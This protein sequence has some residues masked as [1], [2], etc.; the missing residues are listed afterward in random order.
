MLAARQSDKAEE[1]AR[2]VVELDPNNADGYVLLGNALTCPEARSRTPS[3][4]LP[5]RSP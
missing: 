3:T 4:P 1:Q 5:R 2:Y